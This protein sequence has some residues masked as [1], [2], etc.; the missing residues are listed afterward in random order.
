VMTVARRVEAARLVPA[1]VPKSIRV[2]RG[3][4]KRLM[5]NGSGLEQGRDRAA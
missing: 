1:R 3:A 5:A 2:M 4:E